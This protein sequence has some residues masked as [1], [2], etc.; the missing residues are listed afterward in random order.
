[1]SRIDN[2]EL[3]QG[4]RD[5]IA[6]IDTFFKTKRFPRI[7]HLK[8]YGKYEVVAQVGAGDFGV[9]FKGRD[10]DTGDRVAIKVPHFT[11]QISK[12]PENHELE[13]VIL[14]E[15]CHPHIVGY[16]DSGWDSNGN[17]FIVTEWLSGRTLA[18]MLP[19]TKFS[20]TKAIDIACQAAE[21]LAHG[22][23]QQIAHCDVKPSNIMLTGDF[24]VTCSIMDMRK[25]WL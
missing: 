6:Y 12:S 15:L 21:G 13:A 7:E 18:E 2:E 11:W 16:V 25:I 10:T 23:R 3:V 20:L 24:E 14:Q 19:K 5:E 4:I 17:W 9:V 22:H 1:M 8:S